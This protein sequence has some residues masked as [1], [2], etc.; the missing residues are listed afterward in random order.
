VGSGNLNQ[1]ANF[2]NELL[3]QEAQLYVDK[4]EEYSPDTQLAGFTAQGF[5]GMMQLYMLLEEH[6]QEAGGT[7]SV[8]SESFFEYVGQTSNHHHFAAPPMGCADAVEP[9]VATCATRVSATQWNGESFD[10]IAENFSGTYLIEGTEIDT[11][12]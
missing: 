8:T 9:Y 3:R 5:A 7:D 10:L 11:G 1:P 2:Q 12:S 6:A 4:L